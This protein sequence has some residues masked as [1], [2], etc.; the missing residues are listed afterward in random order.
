MSGEAAQEFAWL[1]RVARG[2]A[3]HWLLL[4]NTFAVAYAALPWIG[5]LLQRA[6]FSR[7]GR[8]IFA[9]YSATC[10]QRPDR[11][12]FIGGYQVCYCHRCTALYSSVA[13]AGLL[14]GLVRWRSPLS[15][16]AL[17]WATLPILVDGLWHMADDL[18]PGL[19][20]RWTANG[21]GSINFWVRMLTGM[22]FGI[23]V[24]LWLYPRFARELDPVW[25]VNRSG[26]PTIEAT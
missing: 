23:T 1:D 13:I 11:S 22:L 21:I 12:F 24:V 20:L 5:P 8:F 7:L 10:H 15:T 9:L 17:G 6:G 19:G 16:R 25:N 4:L 2:V 26:R 14:Y 3:R 18:L